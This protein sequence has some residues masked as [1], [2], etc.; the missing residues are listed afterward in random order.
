MNAEVF[1]KKYASHRFKVPSSLIDFMP[2]AMLIGYVN[3]TERVILELDV[4][5]LPMLNSYGWPV[6][7]RC[8]VVVEPDEFYSINPI[9]I[10]VD[11]KKLAPPL[12]RE[13]LKERLKKKEENAKVQVKKNIYTK[14]CT[15]CGSPAAKLRTT[16]MCS[17]PSCRS[18]HEVLKSIGYKARK[19]R[20]LKCRTNKCNGLAV[21][22]SLHSE[23]HHYMECENG[24]DFLVPNDELKEN[25]LV[26][27]TKIGND[28]VERIWNGK[29]W[30]P[31]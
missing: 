19:C 18:R 13:E 15:T 26:S 14:L 10:S 12:T 31:Y 2:F 3:N 16:T 27:Y 23:I 5:H 1:A 8:T 11:Y 24:H 29:T 20:V 28:V 4:K 6:N 7:D 21:Y 25:D 9:V 30:E 17:N 22:V